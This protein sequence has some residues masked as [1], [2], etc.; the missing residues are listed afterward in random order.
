MKAVVAPKA[1]ETVPRVRQ[2]PVRELQLRD[3]PRRRRQR[4]VV[5]DAEP[6]APR[7]AQQPRG[8]QE[9]DGRQ[10]DDDGVHGQ[11]GEADDGA[12]AGRAGVQPGD[13][14]RLRLHG[15]SHDG[16]GRELSLGAASLELAGERARLADPR[17]QGARRPHRPDRVESDGG[18][19]P[20]PD[21]SRCARRSRARA[22]PA[23]S[24]RRWGCRRR[25]PRSRP[26][27]RAPA[28]PSTRIA[29]V[30]TASSSESCSFLFK[31][32]CDPG[33]A[34]LV[35]E[36]SYPLYDYLAHLDG[37][38]ARPLP[39]GVRRQLAHRLRQRERGA[40]GVP[41]ARNAAPRG[42]RRQSEQPHRVVPRA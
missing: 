32:L 13:Q 30:I 5:Q 40:R 39:A 26:S 9:A 17:A 33:D 4:R 19:A 18:R 28:R 7:A 10:A 25:A 23:T 42:D 41:R 20:L 16:E 11:A 35:P 3:L 8:L 24:P 2:Q 12:A 34:V 31:L 29:I 14:D 6:Q 36:P 22:A 37:V 1:K 21:R 38:V 27:T 15:M